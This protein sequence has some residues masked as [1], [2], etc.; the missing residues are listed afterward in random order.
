M[1]L[2]I[3]PANEVEGEDKATS[4]EIDWTTDDAYLTGLD[5]DDSEAEL[6]SLVV[7]DLK[8]DFEGDIE[9]ASDSVEDLESSVDFDDQ[10]ALELSED[11]GPQAL[12]NDVDAASSLT[13]MDADTELAATTSEE[14]EASSKDA[15]ESLTEADVN[16]EL[17][18]D[19]DSIAELDESELEAVAGFDF[20]SSLSELDDLLAPIDDDTE[21]DNDAEASGV[22]IAV[23]SE[24]T[25]ELA[26]GETALENLVTDEPEAGESVTEKAFANEVSFADDE[27]SDGDEG[28]ADLEAEL[29]ALNSSLG[30]AEL[31]DGAFELVDP[32][33]EQASAGTSEDENAD[34]ALLGGADEAATKLDLARAYINMED[35]EG[36]MD[37]LD[38]V[39]EESTDAALVAE[40][41]AMRDE[42]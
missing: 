4:E 5:D 24:D 16:S 36:A 2:D 40:A 14:D 12:D 9:F 22:E 3:E 42:L 1:D 35:I 34:Y 20:D 33:T 27:D 8:A 18:I 29:N 30:E 13:D 6:A 32:A 31:A 19:L 23:E 41:R 15:F 7:E 38:E 11:G 10:A 28:M 37:L 26:L 25:I 39:I 21:S 17:V